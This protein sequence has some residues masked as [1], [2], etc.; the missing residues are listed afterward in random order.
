MKDEVYDFTFFVSRFWKSWRPP[1][2][3]F[4]LRYVAACVP[5]GAFPL[6]PRGEVGLSE[7]T[8]AFAFGG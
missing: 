1:G 8:V 6:R 4:N 3:Q 7:T 2:F 5:P